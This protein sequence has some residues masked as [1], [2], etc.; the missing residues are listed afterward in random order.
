MAGA[1]V[2]VII[3]SKLGS[4]QEPSLIF[5]LEIDK[6]LEVGFHSIVLPFGLAVS[7]RIESCGKHTLNA[8]EVVE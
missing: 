1:R 2:F 3:I 5:L 6:G 7:L 4:C 8:K